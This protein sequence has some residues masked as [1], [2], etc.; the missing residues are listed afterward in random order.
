MPA[1]SRGKRRSV[2]RY[3]GLPGAPG[4]AS[5]RTRLHA[6]RPLVLYAQGSRPGELEFGARR[7]T[8]NGGTTLC[9]SRRS[10]V[11]EI[12]L[13]D[14]QE[15]ARLGPARI[16]HTHPQHYGSPWAEARLDRTVDRAAGHRGAPAA[17]R[18]PRRAPRIARRC[19]DRADSPDGAHLPH[20]P[21]VSERNRRRRSRGVGFDPTS[22]AARIEVRV[23]QAAGAKAIGEDTV[24]LVGGF[25][26]KLVE[27][28]VELGGGV[29]V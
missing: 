7:Q 21:G 6:R 16:R 15:H 14:A 4:S 24:E 17:R 28:V 10:H 1:R 20:W 5:L 29:V 8:C 12:L 25:E 2:R 23:R 11:I 18:R 3:A 13:P 19:D 27:V 26:A 9:R 22:A